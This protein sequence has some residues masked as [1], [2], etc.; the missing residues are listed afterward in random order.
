MGDGLRD[1]R[2]VL[3]VLGLS[4]PT[5]EP[6]DLGSVG[7]THVYVVGDI[8]MKCDD[9]FGSSAMVRE[10][11][12]LELLAGSGLPVPEVVATGQFD[13]TRRWI[14]VRRLEGRPPPDAARPAHELSRELAAQLG[15]IAA[16]LHG[17]AR[18]PGFGTWVRGPRTLADEERSRWESLSR[19]A[20]DADLVPSAVLEEIDRLGRVT[21][22]S[23]VGWSDPVLAHRDVQPRNVL[24][25]GD[26]VS[27]LLDFESAA[28]GDPAEDFKVIGLDWTT[29]SYAAFV[30]AYAHAGGALGADAADRVAHHVLNWVLV[31]FAYLGAIAPAYIGAA[32]TALDRVSAGERPSVP[33]DLIAAP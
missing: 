10:Q 23:V 30:H 13:D 5:Q 28:G 22:D 21:I 7:R 11:S 25:V 18:P 29:P 4:P 1:L 17:G 19:M 24:M 20:R 16:R 15:D 3:D 8:V 14:V 2:C 27:A 33:D 12:A 9:R 32:R 6:G 31:V 26:E